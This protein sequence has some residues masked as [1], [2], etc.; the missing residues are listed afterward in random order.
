MLQ[1]VLNKH[2][3]TVLRNLLHATV[4]P[5]LN[6]HGHLNS[7]CKMGVCHRYVM[8]AGFWTFYFFFTFL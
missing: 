2:V 5:G 8:W 4:D 1:A 6:S 7:E 3:R